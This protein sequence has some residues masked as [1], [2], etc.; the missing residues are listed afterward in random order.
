MLANRIIVIAIVVA[1]AAG[2]SP[3]TLP[4]SPSPIAVGGGGA[5]YNG[6]VIYRR[7][8]GNFAISEASQTLNLSL[9]VGDSNQ[10]TGRFDSSSGT[11]TLAGVLSGD[12]AG[13]TFD[14]TILVITLATQVSGQTQ[15]EGRGQV[16]GTLA[17]RN[18]T[19]RASSIV[20]ENCPGLTVTSDA[21]ALAVSPIPGGI[22]NSAN[23]TIS[24]L[25]GA[26]I[27][28]SSCEGGGPGYPFT[29]Q[30]AETAGVDV[31]LDSSFTVEQR[32]NF[33]APSSTVLDMPFTDLKGGSRRTYDACSPVSGTYQAF[34]SGQDANGNRIRISSPV[35]TFLP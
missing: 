16:I 14:A 11:G 28:R 21:Q 26:N 1:G 10:V 31:T 27:A 34:F 20:Y 5:R 19:W 8:G 24:V 6:S 15:C 33:G 32:R 29:V 12:L 35:V 25:G 17:G 7:T 18:L 23:V 3:G 2:C 13:G 9:V 30:M 22:G 4:G